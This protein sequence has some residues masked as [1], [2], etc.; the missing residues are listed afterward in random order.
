ME[1]EVEVVEVMVVVD[2]QK[3]EVIVVDIMIMIKNVKMKMMMEE[4]VVMEE[5]KVE[6]VVEIRKEEL[7]QLFNN[8]NNLNHLSINNMYTINKY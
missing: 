3:V 5:I 4:V 2:F 1:E 7:L 6:M 8:K